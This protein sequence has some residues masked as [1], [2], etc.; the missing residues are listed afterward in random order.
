MR[1]ERTE[2]I[3]IGA[4]LTGLAVALT[5]ADAHRPF[6][7][8]EGRNRVGGRILS[9]AVP[10]QIGSGRID[11]G[12]AWFWPG[13]PRIAAALRRF[14]L[15]QDPQFATGALVFEDRHG[16]ITPY[17]GLAPMGNAYRIRGG[18]A[19]LT[20]A[21]AAA[22]PPG[23]VRTGTLVSEI[24]LTDDGVT[25][26]GAED[27]RPIRFVATR[28][29]LAMPPRLSAALL[30]TIDTMP[31]DVPTAL[32]AIPTWMA[33]HAK[34]VA[35]Y[36]TPFWRARGLSGD[37]ISHIGPLAEIH[38]ASPLHGSPDGRAGALFGFVGLDP[39]A[40]F[41]QAGTW[42]D[43]ARAQLVR[44]FGDE[45]AQPSALWVKDW[46]EDPLTATLEDRVPLTAHP[47][48]GPPR[49]VMG[50]M[51][52]R[53]VL[54]GTELA[55]HSGGLMEGALEA[56]EHAARQILNAARISPRSAP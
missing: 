1:C 23:T 24:R 48:Y 31:K 35:I 37:A 53:I 43:A 16:R 6:L 12:P 36:P 49:E 50:W 28:V 26:L 44:L 25:V 15:G 30:G 42:Q 22:L 17:P 55:P 9:E 33:G 29:V 11:L 52:P 56:A 38:D 8:L 19:A 5:L 14:S 45:A 4:G 41:D 7:L 2:T 46:A 40:R 27:H 51:E 21:M 13:Q 3:V 54:T 10:P 32:R 20:E 34:L 39:G 18:A 47:D